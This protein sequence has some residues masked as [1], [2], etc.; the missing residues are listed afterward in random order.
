MKRSLWLTVSMVAM[1]G[2]VAASAERPPPEILA[3]ITK[4]RAGG[5][6]TTDEQTKLMAWQQQQSFR[7]GGG[8]GAASG[9]GATGTMPPDIAAIMAKSQR[10]I[11]PTLEEIQKLQAWGKKVERHED[12]RR[13]GHLAARRRVA[14]HQRAQ[15]RDG[16]SA[17]V[18]WRRAVADS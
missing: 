15:Q 17:L 18:G 5:Q 13:N 11:P 1:V 8:Q 4:M 14:R 9:D 6:V 3:I 12:S 2:A 7:A 16:R 10:G